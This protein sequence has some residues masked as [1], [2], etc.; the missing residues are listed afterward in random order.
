[1]DYLWI[2]L[3]A[4]N[5]LAFAAFWNDKK[6]AKLRLWRIPEHILFLLALLGGGIGALAGMY[7]MR[8]KTKRLHFVVGIPA[9]TIFEAIAL[10]HIV[11]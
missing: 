6:R 2:W 1:M 10:Y 4:I 3:I 9:I 11:F 8:H 5:I 7:L